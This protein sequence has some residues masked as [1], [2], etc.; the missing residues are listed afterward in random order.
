MF[1]KKRKKEQRTRINKMTSRNIFSIENQMQV[2]PL[3]PNPKKKNRKNKK[4]KR[5]NK[6][7]NTGKKEH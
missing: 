3:E 1:V 4:N 5:K 6:K 7:T 2:I